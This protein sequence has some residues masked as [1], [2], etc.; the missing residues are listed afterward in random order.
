MSVFLSLGLQPSGMSALQG[1][2]FGE[3]GQKLPGE[4]WKQVAPTLDQ[5]SRARQP[6]YRAP[7]S[8]EK[9][10]KG[11]A[12]NVLVYFSLFGQEIG[13]RHSL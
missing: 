7:F 3:C 8:F 10:R 5:T 12:E 9:V 2:R 4:L 6:L 11:P 13:N 1:P